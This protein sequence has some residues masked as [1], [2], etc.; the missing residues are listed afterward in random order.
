MTL[1]CRL[2]VA[3]H[4][5]ATSIASLHVASWRSAYR[6]IFSDRY[7]DGPVEAERRALWEDRMWNP[8]AGQIV[9]LADDLGGGLV[10][11]ACGFIDEDPD[12]GS[13]INNL[14]V[15]PDCKGG[16]IG[17][18]LMRD[19]GRRFAEVEPERPVHLFCLEQ[20]RAARGFYESLGG[21]VVERML[22]IEAD[23]STCPDLRI[24]WPS[25][26]K[27][28]GSREAPA[29]PDPSRA[30]ANPSL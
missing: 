26:A 16:G 3:S 15:R 24:V 5:D 11:F 28:L 30:I 21:Q 25:P 18:A 27:L 13:F 9:V 17:R 10:G 6:G 22:S 8:R 29:S 12:W 4:A 20:N 2:R 19:L 7:L 1:P 14:H 23:G